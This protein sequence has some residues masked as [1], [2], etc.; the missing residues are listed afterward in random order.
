MLRAEG[1][2][3]PRRKIPEPTLTFGLLG[4]GLLKLVKR[5]RSP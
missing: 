5:R 4:V 1:Q 2:A 3:A